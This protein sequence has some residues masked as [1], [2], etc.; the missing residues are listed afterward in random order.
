MVRRPSGFELR[1]G[2]LLAGLVAVAHGDV[3]AEAREA[4][5]D[6]STDSAGAAGDDRRLPREGDVLGRDHA[7]P[8]ALDGA[9][10]R[11]VWTVSPSWTDRLSDHEGAA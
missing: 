6:G 8:C 5:G 4:Q 7:A 9:V 1:H 3:G 11:T 10:R 2:L